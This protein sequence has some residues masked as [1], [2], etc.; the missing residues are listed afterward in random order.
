MN[1]PNAI[2]VFRVCMIPFFLYFYGSRPYVALVIFVAAA[3]SDF[4]DGYLARKY[5]LVTNFGK[6][7]D[8]LADKLLVCAALIIMAGNLIPDWAVVLLISR[9]FYVSG[10]R[11]LALERNIVMAASWWAKVKTA[12]QMIMIVFLLLPLPPMSNAAL[13]VLSGT[14]FI[15]IAASVVLSVVSAAE[16]TVKNRKVFAAK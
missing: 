1:L 3:L 9:E 4:L 16:Y 2:T 14:E 7:M 11:Q 5:N 15:L 8:P 13:R 10:L 6:L 12:V